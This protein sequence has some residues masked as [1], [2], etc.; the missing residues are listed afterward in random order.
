MA[1]FLTC[2][3][4]EFCLTVAELSSFHFWRQWEHFDG[5][6]KLEPFPRPFFKS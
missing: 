2:S 1:K 4:G 3:E 5:T 6:S